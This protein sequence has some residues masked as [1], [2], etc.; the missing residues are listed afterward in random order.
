MR[1]ARAKAMRQPLLE[2]WTSK[3]SQKRYQQQQEQGEENQQY[4]QREQHFQCQ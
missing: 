2:W 1:V 3:G 4:S